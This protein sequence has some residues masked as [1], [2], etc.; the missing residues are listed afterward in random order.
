MRGLLPLALTACSYDW[1]VASQGAS[2]SGG[3][4]A[5]DCQMLSQ[6][7]L[8]S[9]QSALMCVASCPN[10]VTDE[11]GCPVDFGDTQSSQSAAAD[12][13]NNVIAFVMQGCV[14]PYCPPQG[15]CRPQSG[16]CMS[17]ECL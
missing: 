6:Q 4:S 7:I 5:E 16:M 13:A 8:A 2:S 15:Q 1:T 9:R 17:G 3:G 11:C 14:A 10:Q 12:F